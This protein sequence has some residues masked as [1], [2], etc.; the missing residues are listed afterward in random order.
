MLP[1]MAIQKQY[2]LPKKLLTQFAGLVARARGGAL[3]HAII[4]QQLSTKAAATIARR[5]DALFEGP[6]RGSRGGAD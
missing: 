1:P 4:S 3:T 5:F 6:P 2:L